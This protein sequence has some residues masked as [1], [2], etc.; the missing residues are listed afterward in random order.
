MLSDLIIFLAQSSS[1]GSSDFRGELARLIAVLC[2]LTALWLGVMFLLYRRTS[3]RRRRQ[4]EG[5]PPLPGLWASLQQWLSGTNSP[6]LAPSAGPMPDLDMLTDLPQPDLAAMMGGFESPAPVDL[7]DEFELPPQP[8]PVVD[9]ELFAATIAL[10]AASDE[11]SIPVQPGDM[12]EVDDMPA[13]ADSI[14]LLRV[15]RD[16]SDGSLIIEIGGQRFT[17]VSELQGANL[18]RRFVN[19]VRD[20]TA[21]LRTAAEQPS[22]PPKTSPKAAAAA[23]QPAPTARPPEVAGKPESPAKKPAPPPADGELPSMAPG[24]MF[25]QMGRVAMGHKPEPLEEA[26]VLSIPD[27]IE[28]VLQKHLADLPEYADRSIHVRPSPFGGVRIEVDGQFY[29]GV[30]DVP[31]DQV[32]ALIQDAVR[33][34]E[35]HQ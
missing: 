9:E 2:V 8:T 24:T 28:Q 22:A 32:R 33:E 20:L 1:S 25:K 29:E 5:L 7:A 6:T 4:Q 19:V 26:P 12:E 27:Q 30:G 16:L 23:P 31:E 10:D 13:P 35:K 34:W 17:S 18:D 15:W 11:E 3:E 21:M 14:E